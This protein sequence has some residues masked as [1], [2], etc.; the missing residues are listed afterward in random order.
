MLMLNVGR[1]VA[2]GRLIEKTWGVDGGDANMLK[3]HI[4]HIRQKLELRE[5]EPGYIRSIVG[6]GYTMEADVA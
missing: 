3:T 5:G 4:C 1:V 2:S 6:V